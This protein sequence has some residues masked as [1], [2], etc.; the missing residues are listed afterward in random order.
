MTAKKVSKI[1][2]E[3]GH[4]V[5]K[6]VICGQVFHSLRSTKK[7]C[8]KECANAARR[9]KWKNRDRTNCEQK[10]MPEKECLLCG[11]IFRPKNKSANLRTCC[12]DCMPDGTQ[13]KRGDFLYK[14]KK[15]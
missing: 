3:S 1:K 9:L 10:L 6:C 8:S 14:L 2:V 15:C 12:Y 7:Y 13:L 4:V 11:N 5:C